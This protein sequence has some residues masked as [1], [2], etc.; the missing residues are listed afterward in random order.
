MFFSEM[1]RK[2]ATVVFLIIIVVGGW[3]LYSAIR[4]SAE[5]TSFDVYKYDY[6]R[7]L[8]KVEF[9]YFNLTKDY[10]E[11]TTIAYANTD[12][13]KYWGEYTIQLNDISKKQFLDVIKKM[14]PKY[15]I[16]EKMNDVTLN[17]SMNQIKPYLEKLRETAKS[18]ILLLYRNVCSR[19]I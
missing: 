15:K 19:N 16:T 18:S 10:K 14:N 4:P 13:E 1:K 8:S 9:V 17:Q 12:D 5:T 11:G 6:Y 2:Y 3:W 7:P